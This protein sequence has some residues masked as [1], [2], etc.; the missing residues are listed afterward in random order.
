VLKKVVVGY[1]AEK[2]ELYID[3]SGSEK[4]HKPADNLS[5]SA[6]MKPIDEIVKIQ[7]LLDKSSLELIGNGGEKVISTM[8]YPDEYATGMSVFADGTAMLKSL[9]VWDMS[10]N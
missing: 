3:C 1:Y 8:I 4:E 9:K 10:K 2:Q 7:V 6:P 5:L